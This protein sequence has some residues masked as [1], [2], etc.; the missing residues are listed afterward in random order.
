MFQLKDFQSI[1]ASMVNFLRSATTEIT[2]FSVGSVE[3]TIL[4][5][6]AVEIDQLYQEMFAGLREGIETS[7][8]RSFGLALYEDETFS[9]RQN[10][11]SGYVTSL[12]RAVDKAIEAGAK[13]TALYDVSGNVT[14]RVKLAKLYEP[15][16]TD[17]AQPV[18]FTQCYVHNGDGST[19][20]EL[21]AAAQRIVDGYVE[22]GTAVIGWKGAGNPCQV[23]AATDVS[24]DAEFIVEVTSGDQATVLADAAAAINEYILGL[25]VGVDF[26]PYCAASKAGRISGIGC[27]TSSTPATVIAVSEKALPGLITVTAA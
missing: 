2:D 23:I 27:V 3:R 15:F 1:V 18:G 19:S 20:A 14:E 21:V 22:N 5:A 13:T 24:V 11:F 8:F 7:V 6:P 17:T 4:E 10:R 16:L 26:S 25:G 12:S 9:D